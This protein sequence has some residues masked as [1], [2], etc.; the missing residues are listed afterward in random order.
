MM[1]QFQKMA[2]Q[3]TQHQHPSS[4]Y[5]CVAAAAL[6]D[7][8]HC[9]RCDGPS[10]QREGSAEAHDG[11]AVALG[12]LEDC[13]P[14]EADRR[15]ADAAAGDEQESTAVAD[16]GQDIASALLEQISLVLDDS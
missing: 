7:A 8:Q 4:E 12:T 14:G 6:P 1:A 2:D 3:M 15:S 13:A 16:A 5:R 9:G 10:A 11:A